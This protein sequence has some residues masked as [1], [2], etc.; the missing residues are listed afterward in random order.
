MKIAGRER[1]ERERWFSYIDIWPGVVV[2]SHELFS[3][4]L[5]S[6]IEVFSWISFSIKF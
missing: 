5:F 1:I 2:P 6:L 4:V 3:Q